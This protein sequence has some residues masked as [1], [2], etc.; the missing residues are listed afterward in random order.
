MGSDLGSLHFTNV[1]IDVNSVV[2]ATEIVLDRMED[3]LIV[4]TA[5]LAGILKVDNKQVSLLMRMWSAKK[6]AS[7]PEKS[8]LS[9]SGVQPRVREL[10]C[11]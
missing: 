6:H 2:A 5:S 1:Q 8:I 10:L 11:G 9:L 3:G 7:L 4:N